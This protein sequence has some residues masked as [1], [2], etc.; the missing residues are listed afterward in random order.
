MT[1]NIMMMINLLAIKQQAQKAK[2]KDEL[3]SFVWHPSR[4][5]TWCVPED[6]KKQTEKLWK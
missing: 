4:L 1:V 3:M 2:I 6:E 5:R